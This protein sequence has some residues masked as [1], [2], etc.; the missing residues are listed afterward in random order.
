MLTLKDCM[1]MSG[2]EDDEI[3][4]IAEHEHIPEIAATEM[5]SYLLSTSDGRRR[6]KQMLIDDLVHACEIGNARR[7][8]GL[9]RVISNYVAHHPDCL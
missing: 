9:R 5:G 6:I 2:L 4:A 1:G 8:N 7:A 3:E